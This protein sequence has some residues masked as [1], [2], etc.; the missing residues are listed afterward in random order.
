MTADFGLLLLSGILGTILGFSV[1]LVVLYT[2]YYIKVQIPFSEFLKSNPQIYTR[3]VAPNDQ[4]K[5]MPSHQPQTVIHSNEIKFPQ[6][7]RRFSIPDPSSA[8]SGELLADQETIVDIHLPATSTPNNHAADEISLITNDNIFNSTRSNSPEM[9]KSSATYECIIP[10]IPKQK[11][12][13]ELRV[14]DLVS[15][16]MVYSF[17]CQIINK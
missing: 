13:L 8:R 7:S 17:V 15:I 2:F 10:Y 14:G 3:L 4:S 1:L 16:I 11:D 5:E 12:D 9:T 6:P